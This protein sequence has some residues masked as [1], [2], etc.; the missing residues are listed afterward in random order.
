MQLATAANAGNKFAWSTKGNKK[1]LKALERVTLDPH[2]ILSGGRRRRSSGTSRRRVGDA[3]RADNGKLFK[4]LPHPSRAD[5]EAHRSKWSIASWAMKPGEVLFCVREGK[6][7]TSLGFRM[8]GDNV[9]YVEREGV[10]PD[11]YFAGLSEA[12]SPADPLR[13][14]WFPQIRP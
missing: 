9:T 6:K 3:R 11:P 13:H 10:K 2:Q 5:I 12:L 4:E 8:F 14:P 7:R 1:R